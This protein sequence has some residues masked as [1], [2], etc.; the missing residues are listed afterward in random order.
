MK[1]DKPI[2]GKF[3]L[4]ILSIIIIIILI[5]YFVMLKVDPK[6]YFSYLSQ[7][8][9]D[10]LN[11]KLMQ[12]N[13]ANT[14]YNL[15]NLTFQTND[16]N[17]LAECK[18]KLKYLGPYST[19]SNVLSNYLTL[20]KNNCGGAGELLSIENDKDYVYNGEFVKEGVYCTVEPQPCNLNT[21]YVV[22]TVNSTICKSKYPRMFGGISASNIIACN[23]ENHPS[24]GS[25]LWDYANNEVV[26][27]NLILM[28]HEDELLPDGSFRFRCKYNETQNKNPYLAHP[29]DRFHP[30]VDKCNDTIYAASYSVHAKVTDSGWECDCGNF[31]ETRVKHLDENN[32]KSICTSCYREF[33]APD[34]YKVPYICFK[35][36]SPF[37]MPKNYSSCIEYSSTG[38]FCSQLSLDIQTSNNNMYFI[39]TA[40]NGDIQES[41]LSTDYRVYK[42]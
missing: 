7:L 37:T 9:A 38:N 32:T 33:I 25:L 5:L 42:N 4:L 15:P 12:L 31:N 3:Y 23:D 21:G 34:Q 2:I 22:A 11:D 20:C 28:T 14:I 27:P 10:V 29:L 30:I 40:V 16:L 26:D 1:V 19:D 35:E 24:T 36:N 41:D 39:N 13:N 17:E 8:K 18:N 6:E